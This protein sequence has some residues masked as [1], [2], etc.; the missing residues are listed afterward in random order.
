MKLEYMTC[1]VIYVAVWLKKEF[2]LSIY[3]N[4][5]SYFLEKI[6]VCVTGELW[7]QQLP[8]AFEHFQMIK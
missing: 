2:S 1:D 5:I 7:F 8:I 6:Q 3:I 4:V